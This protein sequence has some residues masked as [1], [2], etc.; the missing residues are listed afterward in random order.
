M[1]GN[2]PFCLEKNGH[3]DT[4]TPNSKKKKKKMLRFMAMQAQSLLFNELL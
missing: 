1:S 2:H 4:G 3:L